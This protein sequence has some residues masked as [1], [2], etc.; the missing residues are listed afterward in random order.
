MDKGPFACLFLDQVYIY[1]PVDGQTPVGETSTM[2]ELTERQAEI[3]DYVRTCLREH[4]A[5]PTRADIAKMFGF[6]SP[7]AAE[8]HL[9]ALATK[10]HIELLPGS[11][12]NIRLLGDEVSLTQQFELPL[13]GRIAAGT[14]LTASENVE[15]TVIV[16]PDLFHPRAD[17]LHRISGH[18]MKDAGILDGD[19][20]GIHAQPD[21]DSG[22]I[23]AAVLPERRSGDDRITL[24][25]Y[26]RRGKK[27]TLKAEN[28]APGYEPIEIDLSQQDDEDR[29]VFR[30]AGIYA[31][32]I[33]I[34]R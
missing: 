26:F 15:S 20:V 8:G 4:G 2:S 29:P 5:P 27:V 19:L 31:G 1:T 25:R 33:R 32:L 13:L 9:R 3:L 24:K 18:S 11:A 10:G 23:I 7:N 12:R 14:P 6:S 30:I 28:D 16:D 21:A 17:F 22:T 34:P